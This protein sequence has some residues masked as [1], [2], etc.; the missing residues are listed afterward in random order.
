MHCHLVAVEVRI[1]SLAHQRMQTDRV[2]FHQRWLK[3]LNTDSVQRWCSVQKNRMIANHLVKN[4]PHVLIATL[5]HTLR[6]LDGVCMTQI[7]QSTNHERLEQLQSDLLWKTALMQ[8]KFRTNHDHASC[9]I[10][11]A[12]TKKVFAESALLALDHIRQ[13]FQRTI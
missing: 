12:F 10:V 3:R 4:I 1:E 6:A 5:K 13:R 11:H 9:R 7:F 2:P 8:L